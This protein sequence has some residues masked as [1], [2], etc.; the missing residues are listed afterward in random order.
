MAGEIV[1]TFAELDLLGAALQLDV[2]QFP[3]AIPHHATATDERLRL[4]HTAQSD[5]AARGLIRNG[6]L[7]PELVR[8]LTVFAK[9]RVSIA[10]CGNADQHHHLAVAAID[11][12]TAVIAVQQHESLHF[13]FAEPDAV[14]R[15]LIGL[16][17]PLKPGPGTS[18][19]VAA[20]PPKPARRPE[21]DFS[22]LTFTSTVRQATTPRAAAVELLRQPRLGGGDFVVT[23]RS[24]HNSTS[25]TMGWLDTHSGR[26]A[27]L[28]ET[29]QDGRLHATYTPSDLA[30]LDRQLTRIVRSVV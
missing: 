19:T 30:G 11:D 21:Q 18:I 14:V 29:D 16:L 10:M 4:A 23:V 2:R 3:F 7:A 8:T 15:R 6:D 13:T 5:L 1:C 26:Y 17:P 24:R 28:N 12:H 20:D 27:V 25:T 22:E 9:A